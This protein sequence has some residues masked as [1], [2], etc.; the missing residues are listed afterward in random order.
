MRFASHING[1][2]DAYGA[3]GAGPHAV[4]GAGGATYGYDANGNNTS[5]D[6]RIIQYTTF[7]KADYISKGGHITTFAYGP[8][9]ARY[10]RVDDGSGG[11]T[12]TRYIGNVE[13]IFQPNGDQDR[14]RYI[15][16]IAVETIHFGNNSVEDYRETHYLHKDHL[17]SLD[18][19]TTADGELF[20]EQSFD[21]WG[22]RRNAI[23]WVGLT[24]AELITFDHDL[25]TRGFTGHEM[26][27]EVGIIHMNGRIYDAKLARF[28]QADPF[29]Q[30]P[31]NTQSLNRFSYVWNNP[32][33][34]TDPSGYFGFLES[35]VL[36]FIFAS[37]VQTAIYFIAESDN[38]LSPINSVLIPGVSQ[39][40]LSSFASV[41]D[42]DSYDAFNELQAD[43]AGPTATLVVGDSFSMISGGNFVNAGF[44]P[45]LILTLPP[46]AISGPTVAPI[47]GRVFEGALKTARNNLFVGLNV[48]ATIDYIRPG[49]RDAA[50]IAT[51]NNAI[52]RFGQ[53]AVFLVGLR[54]EIVHGVASAGKPLLRRSNVPNGAAKPDL[55]Q[56]GSYTNTH[57]SGRTYS[58]KGSRQRSQQSGRRQARANED[59]HTATDWTPADN[60]RDAFKQESLRIDQNG[61]VS[62]PGNY[63]Q[64]ESPGRRFR[65]EDREL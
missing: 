51:F 15:A 43:F 30:D 34:A 60:N 31:L 10:R 7:D 5:G 17:G 47:Q 42:L 23:D 18:V 27:D 57:E 3:G 61:S 45:S 41:A 16:G 59:P 40:S 35:L 50:D 19:I 8:D 37:T 1:S 33:N 2:Y 65:I 29:I 22:Q 20:Q 21:A 25:T 32:L 64:I 44:T 46:D 53:S 9:R 55:R 52:G 4:T 54:K 36:P 49:I 24:P 58:G 63:N 26:L 13:I 38:D 11:V 56:T 12:T 48:F 14:K 39:N 62:S 6:G 28:L